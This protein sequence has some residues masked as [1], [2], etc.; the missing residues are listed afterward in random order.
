MKKD[1]V[2]FFFP[3]HSALVVEVCVMETTFICLTLLVLG[4]IWTPEKPFL[5]HVGPFFNQTVR[6]CAIFVTAVTYQCNNM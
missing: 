4:F 1:N 2:F 6:I 5:L 3:P